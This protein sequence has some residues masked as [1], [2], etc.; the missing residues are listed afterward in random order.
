MSA[1]PNPES[2]LSAFA[3]RG[4]ELLVPAEWEPGALG[5][6]DRA[7]YVRF[8]DE[9]MPRCE[10]R[11]AK[12]D[13][14]ADFQKTVDEFLEKLRAAARRQK[15]SRD[16]RVQDAT[17]S[18][19][20]QPVALR[21]RA[22]RW[23]DQHQY[24]LLAAF[25]S[26]CKNMTLLQLTDCNASLARQIAASLRDHPDGAGTWWRLYRLA[27]RT[28]ND[29]RLIRHTLAA[30]LLEMEFRGADGLQAQV[31]RFGP[32]EILLK[33]VSLEAFWRAR[34]PW[35]SPK[36]AI[37]AERLGN[38]ESLRVEIEQQDWR[39]KLAR[40]LPTWKMREQ[41]KGFSICA[42]TWYCAASN[43]IYAV[44]VFA[45][46]LETARAADWTV[47]CHA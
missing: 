8:D 12:A 44:E 28:P 30:G 22:H 31:R 18:V 25:C 6:D 21:L 15:P 2:A 27:L 45:P 36:Q 42:R 33:N 34:T 14:E 7:G 10:I 40:A 26:E 20:P 11:W 37:S 24:L 5:G 13:D 43:R 35:L 38:D 47:E 23:R 16:V 41:K 29:W 3:W 19:A 9:W 4:L 1:A 32:A 17:E 46:A 39:A